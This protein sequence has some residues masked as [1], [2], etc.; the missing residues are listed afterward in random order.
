MIE[1][2]PDLQELLRYNLSCEGYQVECTER[3]KLGVKMVRQL[4]C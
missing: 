4:G 2:E 1:N 3:G